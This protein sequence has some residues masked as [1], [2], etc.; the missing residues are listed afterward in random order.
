MGNTSRSD[1][2]EARISSS[3]FLWR[4]PRWS[5]G[6]TLGLGELVKTL[7]DGFSLAGWTLVRVERRGEVFR[8][9]RGVRDEKK[10]KVTEAIEWYAGTSWSGQ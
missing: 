10:K 4:S 3:W 1:S 8:M 7:G 2:T 5:R 6:V 9:G